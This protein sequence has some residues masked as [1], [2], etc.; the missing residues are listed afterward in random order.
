MVSSLD[1]NVIIRPQRDRKNFEF[2]NQSQSHNV[3][4]KLVQGTQNVDE[5]HK[6]TTA[7]ENQKRVRLDQVSRLM[8]LGSKKT[9]ARPNLTRSTTMYTAKRNAKKQQRQI[10]D[11]FNLGD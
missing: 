2:R 6:P 7:T 1:G 11:I 8:E 9:N 5:M 3:G 10:K 4:S